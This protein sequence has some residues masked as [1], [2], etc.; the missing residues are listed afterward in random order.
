LDDP[1]FWLAHV[2]PD[3]KPRITSALEQALQGQDSLVEYRFQRKDGGYSWMRDGATIVRDVHGRPMELIGYFIDITEQKKL[4]VELI[5]EREH[6]ECAN[7]AKTEFLANMSHELRTPLNAVI[8]FSE[9]IQNETFGAVGS[10]RYL[11]YAKD[12]N[13]SGQYLLELITDILDLSKVEA[14]EANLFEKDIDVTRVAGACL[15]IVS[16]RAAKSEVKIRNSIPFDLPMLR[17]DERLLKQMI[18]NLLANAVKFTPSG[19]QVVLYANADAQTGL[20]ITVEDNGIGMAPEA[21]SRVVEP[22]VQVDTGLNRKYE[23]T[24]LGLAL[25]AKMVKFHGGSL[26]LKSQLGAGT[27]ATLR[28]PTERLVS[29]EATAVQSL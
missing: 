7:R 28:F 27:S 14:G 18:T 1:G 20:A 12:I 13:E 19:G 9:L 10:S 11:D 15:T 25:T 8:G 16:D 23:G 4:E 24:G 29:A 17:A 3:D 26:E 22:F 21:L 6:A 2:H 5:A